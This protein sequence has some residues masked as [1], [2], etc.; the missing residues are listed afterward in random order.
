MARE[1]GRLKDKAVKNIIRDGIR[2]SHYDGRGLTLKIKANGSGAWESRY[3]FNGV[4]RYYG[5]GSTDEISLVEARER[6]RRLVRLPLLDGTDP[7]V[8]KRVARASAASAAAKAMTFAQACDQYL[9]Q[10]KQQ[11]TWRSPKHAKQWA[12]TLTTYALPI[13]GPM[14]VAAIDVPLVLKVLEQRIDADHAGSL[15]STRQETAN[16]LRGRLES[17]LDWCKARQ[18]RSGDNPA[19]F[20]VI[21]KV[22]KLTKDTKHHEAMP[23]K[24]IPDFMQKLRAREGS[25]AR[26]LE[27]LV[28]T[29]ARS[30]EVIK[31]KWSEIDLD[32][33]VWTV[34]AEH[35]KMGREHRVPLSDTAVALLRELPREGDFIFIGAQANKP[36]G[37]ST[38]ARLLERMKYNVTVHGF[39]SG[40]RDWAG[41]VTSFAHDICETALAHAKGKTVEAYQ[42]GDLFDKRRRLM[43]AW[44]EYCAIRASALAPDNVVAI[45]ASR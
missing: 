37:H 25:A 41:E 27:F 45:G 20:D 2:G 16:R 31:A 19:S 35:M 29:A 42:R 32:D 43:A 36:L 39:R 9:Q 28:L 40:F 21:G 22:L 17:I 44:S 34:P 18:L 4:V 26:A 6:N 5:L 15:W 8:A 13:I 1:T 23:F 11:G 10:Q 3:Q 24:N 38:M 33:G 30:Q 7:L 14:P 12:S